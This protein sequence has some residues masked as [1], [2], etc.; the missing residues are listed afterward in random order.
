MVVIKRIFKDFL[1]NHKAANYQDVVLGL[2]ISHTAM[3]C[4]ISPK[5]QFLELNLDFSSPKISAKSVTN[6]VKYFTKTLWLWKIGTKASGP[7]VCCQNIAG[8]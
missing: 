2:L 3:G 8:H 4:N 6:T 1:G 7:H 5:I